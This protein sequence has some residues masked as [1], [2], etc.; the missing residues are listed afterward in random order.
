MATAESHVTAM[1]KQ[2]SE[3]ANVNSVAQLFQRRAGVDAQRAA[4]RRKVGGAWQEITW[5]VL[6]Q[7]VEEAGWG[8][9]AL[10]LKKGELGSILA[11]A[12][13][14]WTVCD[15]GI[16]FAGGAVVPI[17]QS[18]TPEECQFIL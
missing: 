7:E 17:Y 13:V 6:A 11:G 14:E 15:L 9:I 10:G 12:R 1:Q 18:N 2:R 16:A 3:L 5:A 4:A 8:F